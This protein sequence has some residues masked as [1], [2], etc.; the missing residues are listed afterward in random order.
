MWLAHAQQS[1]CIEL[2]HTVQWCISMCIQWDCAVWTFALAHFIHL[3]NA[4]TALWLVS[5]WCMAQHFRRDAVHFTES[6]Y[7]KKGCQQSLS[8]FSS[9]ALCDQSDVACRHQITQWL[10]DHVS[11]LANK[12]SLVVPFLMFSCLQHLAALQDMASNLH[13]LH[14]P[15]GTS[16]P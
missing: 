14:H 4:P 2:H 12:G 8:S 9:A 10:L 16:C 13:K 3:N 1:P 15:A 6:P 5:G 11:A 7:L